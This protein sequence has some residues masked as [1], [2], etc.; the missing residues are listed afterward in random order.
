[1][2]FILSFVLIFSFFEGLSQK[3]APLYHHGTIIIAAIGADG[4]ILVTDSRVTLMDSTGIVIAN[5]D[6]E[7]KIYASQ[8]FATSLA[9]YSSY[10]NITFSKIISDFYSTKILPNNPSEFNN[11]L[12]NFIQLNYIQ[13][14][15]LM[16]Q[17]TLITIGKYDDSL[18]ISF[19]NSDYQSRYINNGCY[20]N[21]GYENIKEYFNYSNTYSCE[22]LK[23]SAIKAIGKFIKKN[24]AE[25]Q[26]GGFISVY[27][28][29]LKGNGSWL[30]K[31]ENGRNYPNYCNFVKDFEKKKIK[32]NYLTT[33]A[34]KHVEESIK[35]L[36]ELNCN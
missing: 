19:R 8:K 3:S 18:C 6:N 32:I 24:N 30:S 22:S 1:M 10:K 25:S 2:K 23:D 13:F 20:T 5:Y 33:N 15:D 31:N 12:L 16:N 27:K 17:N 36:K 11:Q 9:G 4:V 14:S 28:I 7:N 26:M 34:K 21:V 29:D 35:K